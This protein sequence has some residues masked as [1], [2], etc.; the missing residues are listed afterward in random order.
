M[1]EDYGDLVTVRHKPTGTDLAFNL[2]TAAEVI[3]PVDP[4]EKRVPFP[5][6]FI[7]WIQADPDFAAGAPTPV[8]V[9]GYPGVQIDVTPAGTSST[10]HKKPF[11][12]LKSSGWNLVT[13]PEKW[14][15]I[16]LD[17]VEGERMLILQISPADSFEQGAELAE[18]LLKALNIVPLGKFPQKGRCDAD[19]YRAA[20]AGHCAVIV[21][22]T[23]LS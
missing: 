9:A 7:R 10:A 13:D 19:W 18:E 17:D 8:T 22:I 11:L 16:M 14:R 5:E 6:D 1:A 21:D 4:A 2:V 12:R 20:R 23:S 3:D 15:F